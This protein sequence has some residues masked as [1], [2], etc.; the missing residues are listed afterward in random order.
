MIAFFACFVF[1]WRLNFC[2]PGWRWFCSASLGTVIY[3]LL[4]QTNWLPCFEGFNQFRLN[5]IQIG[6]K[7]PFFFNLYF[8]SNSPKFIYWHWDLIGIWEPDLVQFCF[9]KIRKCGFH[10]FFLGFF[11][12][13]RLRI[14][15]MEYNWA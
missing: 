1:F 5:L 7:I 10:K 4:S 12:P 15:I 9:Q 8:V 11:F 2:L 3:S 6:I 14:K 13:F